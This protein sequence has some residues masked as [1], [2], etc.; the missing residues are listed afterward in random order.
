M[1][2]ERRR[3]EDER[4]RLTMRIA[5]DV[6]RKFFPAAPPSCAGFDMCRASHP[7]EA[8]AGDYYDYMT[9][10]DGALGIVVADV[11]GHG[12]GPALL[13]SATPPPT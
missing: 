8:T 13:M 1:A 2:E 5:Q 9:L 4:V 6:Q 10:P 3:A 12:F 11:C 7:A